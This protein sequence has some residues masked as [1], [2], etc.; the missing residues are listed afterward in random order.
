MSGRLCPN[1]VVEYSPCVVGD[2]F[3]GGV[4]I[5]L[6][7]LTDSGLKALLVKGKK[8][9]VSV[10]LLTAFAVKILLHA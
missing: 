7:A 4:F 5:A 9:R 8:Y 3:C 6:I 10:V 2:K 1:S